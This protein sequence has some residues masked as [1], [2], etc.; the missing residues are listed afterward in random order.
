MIVKL[1]MTV[2]ECIEQY[3]DL[4]KKI[5]GKPH[6]IGK[7]TGGFGATKYSSRRLHKHIVRLIKS[8]G[9][10][11]TNYSMEETDGHPD[12]LCSVVC[13]E[14][15]NNWTK[16]RKPNPVLLCSHECRRRFDRSAPYQR[17][18]VCDAGRATASAP[19][20]F[21]PVRVLRKTLV[22]GGFGET[23]NPSEAAWV[24]YDDRKEILETDLALW[25][26]VGTG[27]S[28][29]VY[30]EPRRDWKAAIL[31][32]YIQN[33]IRL[34]RN[35]EKIA[36]DSEKTGDRMRMLSKMNRNRLVFN[37]F[38]AN[39]GVHSIGLDE[40]EMV[41]NGR[42]QELT[43]SYLKTERERL[44]IVANALAAE[45]RV[46]REAREF[47]RKTSDA[48][49]AA[50]FGLGPSDSSTR[51][52]VTGR[53]T[54]GQLLPAGPDGPGLS[55]MSEPTLTTSDPDRTPPSRNVEPGDLL[56]VTVLEMDS[57][58]F[59]DQFSSHVTSDPPLK[60]PRRTSSLPVSK[61]EWRIP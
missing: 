13:R 45:V 24:H 35:L 18:N 61:M 60:R 31:P 36:T 6:V 33:V 28:S 23:N 22:D 26:N 54:A 25:V 55:G 15:Q 50:E 48:A 42:M 53:P 29:D 20:Y 44:Q 59:G 39:T 30:V 21:D 12:L 49:I 58:G 16:D 11:G 10:N 47:A 46:R 2:D 51:D 9:H 52:L 14:L 17:C 19:T 43:Q 5:F 57:Q 38:S 1:N 4:S 8:R 56:E 7:R 40:F 32:S 37:R 34:A 27:T 41:E 3:K